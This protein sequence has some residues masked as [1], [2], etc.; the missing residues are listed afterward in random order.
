MACACN[1]VQ[2]KPELMPNLRVCVCV[3]VYPRPDDFVPLTICQS[4]TFY[5]LHVRAALN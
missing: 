3:H 4:M 2:P 1:P 5:C